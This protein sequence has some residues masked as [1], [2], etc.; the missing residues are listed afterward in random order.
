MWNWV[1]LSYIHL[2]QILCQYNF[3]LIRQQHMLAGVSASV[4]KTNRSGE[5]STVEFLKNRII[6]YSAC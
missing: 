4:L 5:K 3:F 2:S 6:G 1:D